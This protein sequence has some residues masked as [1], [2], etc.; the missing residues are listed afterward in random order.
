V[1]NLGRK[2]IDAEFLW[3]TALKSILGRPYMKGKGNAEVDIGVT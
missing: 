3:G 1:D 2:A